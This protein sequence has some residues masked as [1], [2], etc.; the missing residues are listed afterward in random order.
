MQGEEQDEGD[1]RPECRVLKHWRS[2]SASTDGDRRVDLVRRDLGAD[3]RL[4]H[5]LGRLAGDR[6][7][8]GERLGS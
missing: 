8:L 4:D 5:R 7:D 3:Q 6:A 1:E 2:S